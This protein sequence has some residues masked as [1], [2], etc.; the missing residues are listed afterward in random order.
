MTHSV[1]SPKRYVSIHSSGAKTRPS[2]LGAEGVTLLLFVVSIGRCGVAVVICHLPV[3][4]VATS[5]HALL[6][7][8][9]RCRKPPNAAIQLPVTANLLRAARTHTASGQGCSSDSERGASLSV[10]LRAAAK[11][12]AEQ[13]RTSSE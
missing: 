4:V 9:S 2:G 13:S 12:G 5:D 8:E 7:K 1:R 10:M 6:E 11:A 3:A